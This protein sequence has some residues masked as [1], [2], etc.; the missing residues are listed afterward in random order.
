MIKF[1]DDPFAWNTAI[2]CM[3]E[4]GLLITNTHQDSK[5]ETILKMLQSIETNGLAVEEATQEELIDFI[6]ELKNDVTEVI[7]YIEN[8]M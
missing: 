3:N 4:E 2:R 5:V 8:D 7:K 1:E 6:S